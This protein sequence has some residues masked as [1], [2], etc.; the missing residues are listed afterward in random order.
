VPKRLFVKKTH[1]T[2]IQFFRY[3]V[4]GL[5]AFGVD[6]GTLYVM[7]DF[8]NVHYLVSN[9]FGFIAGLF[10]NYFLSIHWV[11]ANRK[12]KNRQKE[13]AAFAMVGL[14]GLMINQL[15]MWSMTDIAGIYYMNSKIVATGVVFFWNFFGRKHIVFY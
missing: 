11:F 6:F 2:K 14:I 5:I 1:N 9:V 15:V 4:V 7:T 10:S 13:F 3:L 8:L 12:I